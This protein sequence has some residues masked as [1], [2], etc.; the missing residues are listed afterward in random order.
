MLERFFLR[1]VSTRWLETEGVVARVIELWTSTKEYFTK[2]LMTS[3]VQSN[4]LA[5]KTDR[6]K[7]IYQFLKLENEAVNLAR[8]QLVLFVARL[9][10]PFLLKL[11]ACR[12][13]V[14]ELY[15][16]CE[17]L[18]IRIGQL[19][20]KEEKLPKTGEA[21]KKL[22]L[23]S[24]KIFKPS[25]EAGF[26]PMLDATL[27]DVEEKE[28]LDLLREMKKAVIEQLKYLQTHLPFS[29]VFI[30]NLSFLHPDLRSSSDLATSAL[31][32]AERLKRFSAA[33]RANLVVQIAIYQG[34]PSNQLPE[35]DSLRGRIDH[36]WRDAFKEIEKELSA[37][38][39]ELQRLVK[40]SASLP[41]GQAFVESGFSTTKY[42]VKQPEP[43]VCEGTEDSSVGYPSC[44]RR[45]P[46]PYFSQ[47]AK[48]CEDGPQ[49]EGHC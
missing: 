18:F 15:A 29:D 6:F 8:L 25:K 28:K 41:H 32:V 38:P 39:A 40:I 11:Q 2:Y 9:C 4:K 46:C 26:R 5:L 36:F 34:L 43:G 31:S 19:V 20:L 27:A 16:Q 49:Q 7:R 33:D 22:D 45:S 12:P 24:D 1:P 10:R 17:A 3:K 37:P 42:V 30:K 48:F 21:I 47:H 14:H 44:W 35:F 13:L 23:S